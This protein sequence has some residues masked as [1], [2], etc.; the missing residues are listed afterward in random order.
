MMT[1]RLCLF[2]ADEMLYIFG[3]QAR[4][5]KLEEQLR[6]HLNL[7]V[8]EDSP[9][10]RHVCA[11]CYQTL[12]AF[13]AFYQEVA[14][15]QTLLTL[16]AQQRTETITF[17]RADPKDPGHYV[18]QDGL[19]LVIANS[20]PIATTTTAVVDIRPPSYDEVQQSKVQANSLTTL[21]TSDPVV[22]DEHEDQ[23]E[24]TYQVE[25]Q[26]MEPEDNDGQ[27]EDDHVEEDPPS[28]E[29]DLFAESE[30]S[31]NEEE[32]AV[33]ENTDSEG[34][35]PKQLLVNGKFV[36]RGEKLAKCMDQFYDLT[37]GICDK[38]EWSTINELFVHYRTVHGATGYV[39]CCDRKMRRTK[40]LASHMATHVQPEA[41]Q[42]HVC[43]KMLTSQQTLRSH[44]KNHLPE[45]KRPLK[46]R[47]CPRRFS[48]TS[49][50]ATHLATHRVSP[51]PSKAHVCD[52]CNRAYRTARGLQDHVAKQHSN[53]GN[54]QPSNGVQSG[55]HV[56]HI[57]QKQFAC[58]SNLGYHM[59]THQ[60]PLQQVQCEQCGKWLKN[61]ICLNKHMMQHS[62]IRH[63]C[64]QCD[65]SAVN[66]QSLQNH[67][68]VQHSSDRPYVC[69]ECGKAFK[70]KSNLQNHQVLHTGEQR[71]ACEFCPRKF[72]SSGNYYTHR[73]RMHPRE[74]DEVKK[75]KEDEDRAFRERT[76]LAK[77]K[78]DSIGAT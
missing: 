31:V 7:I 48:Y 25:E 54:Q 32:P 68:R 78:R 11:K 18:L 49:V 77:T 60:P 65:Y 37:C 71:Y 40:V 64:N 58:R 62:Q 70:L 55:N 17:V 61:R 73:K 52:H 39:Q 36:V 16:N 44:L 43:Q 19:T 1:C 69:G 12:V 33:P 59:T 20:L 56:C 46:C 21:Q 26:S 35:L 66:V 23:Y 14:Q 53:P 10:P 24:E 9:L 51:A 63:S 8:T 47:Y 75:R 13:D 34:L 57:C 28:V 72:F 5:V 29:H 30:S 67:I 2:G 50:L 38:A 22:N 45:E 74:V 6:N 3:E 42:C 41:F 4:A 27:D 76:I 15:N